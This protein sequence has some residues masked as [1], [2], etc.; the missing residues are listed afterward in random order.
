[1]EVTMSNLVIYMIGVVLVVCALGYGASLLNIDPKW[2]LIG[3]LA[4]LGFGVMAG[5][6]KT[7]R[8]DPSTSE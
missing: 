5:V 7:R 4:I 2:I 3:A 6:V 1:V 8:R